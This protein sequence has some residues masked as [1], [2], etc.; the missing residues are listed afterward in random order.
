MK[1][2]DACCDCTGPRFRFLLHLLRVDVF[3]KTARVDHLSGGLARWRPAFRFQRNGKQVTCMGGHRLE[4]IATRIHNTKGS[5]IL[6]IGNVPQF[7]AL[8]FRRLHANCP[9]PHHA[10]LAIHADDQCRLVTCCIDN[11]NVIFATKT[12]VALGAVIDKESTQAES[13]KGCCQGKA[14]PLRT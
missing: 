3:Y 13:S 14:A 11:C 5:G 4:G 9:H 12:I 10:C 7:Q 2:D 1:D 8:A 6:T